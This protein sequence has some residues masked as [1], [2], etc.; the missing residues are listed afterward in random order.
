MEN[1]ER[2]PEPG[3]ISR[4]QKLP[5][6]STCPAPCA[7]KEQ[8]E[9]LSPQTRGRPAQEVEQKIECYGLRDRMKPVPVRFKKT[10]EAIQTSKCFLCH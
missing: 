8:D 5:T 10:K 6:Y 7:L 4:K 9:V 2:K 1:R 3:T